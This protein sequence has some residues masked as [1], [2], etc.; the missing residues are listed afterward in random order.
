M[1]IFGEKDSVFFRSPMVY[2]ETDEDDDLRVRFNPF[3]A[4]VPFY[5]RYS[6]D[7][8]CCFCLIE[9]KILKLFQIF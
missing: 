7:G 9:K 5:T 2:G 3:L 6:P 8:N 4:G 1:D